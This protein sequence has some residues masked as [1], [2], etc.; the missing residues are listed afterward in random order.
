MPKLNKLYTRTGDQGMTRLADGQRVPKDSPRVQAYGSVDEL[1]SWLGYALSMDLSEPL[2]EAVAKI[3]NELFD[4]GADLS[5]PQEA[6]TSFHVPRIE[7]RHVDDLESLIDMLNES[8]SPLDNFVLPGGD[9]AAAA[10]H[11]ARAVCRRS[12][13]E[14]MVMSREQP[15]GD[16]VLPY[17]NRLSDALFVMARWQNNQTGRKEPIWQP[18]STSS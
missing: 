13:R 9:R 1:N 11:I 6:E 3:Q 15:I 12:E 14:V 2:Q 18:G 7:Q 4:L 17:I 8:L 10:L 5:T 16:Y